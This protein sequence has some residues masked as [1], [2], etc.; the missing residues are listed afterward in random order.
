MTNLLTQGYSNYR[1]EKPSHNQDRGCK[2]VQEAEVRF[3]SSPVLQH[4][5]RHVKGTN[6]KKKQ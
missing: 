5:G 6:K 4:V 1:N 3:I 2:S